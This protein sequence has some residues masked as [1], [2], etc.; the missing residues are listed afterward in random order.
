MYLYCTFSCKTFVLTAD[1]E[2]ASSATCM[3]RRLRKSEVID[4][5]NNIQ[6]FLNFFLFNFY[7]RI[8]PGMGLVEKKVTCEVPHLIRVEICFQ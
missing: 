7:G 3:C 1:F 4:E 8:R 5:M 6:Y 2:F